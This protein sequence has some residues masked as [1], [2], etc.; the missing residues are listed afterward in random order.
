MTLS[1]SFVSHNRAVWTRAAGSD[2]VKSA[3]DVASCTIHV[4]TNYSY[5]FGRHYSSEYEDTLFGALFGTEANTKRIVST[6]I[7]VESPI[8][9]DGWGSALVTSE[10]WHE[11]NGCST[12]MAAD[13][14]DVCCVGCGVVYEIPI[15]TD[16]SSDKYQTW[17]SSQLIVASAVICWSGTASNEA[18]VVIISASNANWHVRWPLYNDYI[19][20]HKHFQ[21]WA[22]DSTIQQQ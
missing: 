12:L 6:S 10:M 16:W 15:C 8:E 17:T 7:V 20:T 22:T 19:H 11:S 18:V 14:A 3:I 9:V 13:V 1:P 2:W 21:Q 4:Q 5:S